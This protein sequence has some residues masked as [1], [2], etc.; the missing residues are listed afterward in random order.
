MS[1]KKSPPRAYRSN[2][3]PPAS[4]RNTSC[5]GGALRMPSEKSMKSTNSAARTPPTTR[6][7]PAAAPTS[8]L[9]LSWGSSGR[10]AR[11]PSDGFAG[12]V[13]CGVPKLRQ[14]PL[15]LAAR[16]DSRMASALPASTAESRRALRASLLRMSRFE[17]ISATRSSALPA[18][19]WPPESRL[20]STALY[21]SLAGIAPRAS[22]K[23]APALARK[24]PPPLSSSDIRRLPRRRRLDGTAIGVGE[25]NRNPV[26]VMIAAAKAMRDAR[27]RPTSE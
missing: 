7:K 26:A 1:A 15:P 20:M 25:G 23:V 12:S 11:A 14:A 24:P 21:L 22:S 3:H 2:A 10:V 8:L 6:V 17:L 4:A 19:C 18:F 27:V 16:R 9:R 5:N 13:S